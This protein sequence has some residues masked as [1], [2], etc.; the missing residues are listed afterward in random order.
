MAYARQAIA[1]GLATE[2]HGA[3]LFRNGAVTSG[4]LQ[5]EQRLDDKA[6]ERLQKQFNEDHIGLTNAHKPMILE[7]GLSWKPIAL[8]QEDSQFLET[9]KYQRDEICAIYRVPPHMIANLDRATFS[10]IE[11]Q[12]MS[13]VN[14]SLVP[15]LTRIE[16]RIRVGLIPRSEQATHYAKFNTAALLRGDLQTRF[17]SY[18][19][20]INWGILSPN[21]CR[22]ME[23]RNPREGGD[24]YLTPTNMTTKPEAADAGN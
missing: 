4:V 13:Y 11:H 7:M 19:K 10:N 22:E 20:G 5:T 12:S 24:I 16:S 18:G 17:D 1:L 6:F 15:Y 23:D 8:N 21:E 9:R 14:Y 2:E 3:R